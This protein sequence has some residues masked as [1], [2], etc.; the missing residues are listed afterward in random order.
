M[1]SPLLES[2]WL[3]YQPAPYE[4]YG[5]T[6]RVRNGNTNL[7]LTWGRPSPWFTPYGGA[8]SSYAC[9]AVPGSPTLPRASGGHLPGES[10]EWTY[11][12]PPPGFPPPGRW[13]PPGAPSWAWEVGRGMLPGDL[14]AWA[15]DALEPIRSEASRRGLGR[16]RAGVALSRRRGWITHVLRKS[17]EV[18]QWAEGLAARLGEPVLYAAVLDLSTVP[19]ERPVRL[20]WEALG[21]EYLDRAPGTV[22]G[23]WPSYLPDCAPRVAWPYLWD[24]AVGAAAVSPREPSPSD[25]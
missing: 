18:R 13:R 14:R 11:E 4:F 3:T 23:Y 19:E 25:P 5:G 12:P 20:V 17:G 24:A 22:A 16:A 15:V 21:Q 1:R 7:L 9:G 6:H 10:S 8:T 2:P